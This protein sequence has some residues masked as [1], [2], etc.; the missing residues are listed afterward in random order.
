MWPHEILSFV[1]RRKAPMSLHFQTWL[2]PS[3]PVLSCMWIWKKGRMR[4]W[5]RVCIVCVQQ[6][7]TGLLSPTQKLSTLIKDLLL[8]LRHWCWKSTFQDRPEEKKQNCSPM[9]TPLMVTIG[10]R[11]I[12]VKSTCFN[13]I[14]FLFCWLFRLTF[15]FFALAKLW[16]L[17]F[18]LSQKARK[19]SI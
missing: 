18:F 15:C 10:L 4:V 1:Y 9:L 2:T 7:R 6:V 5:V 19:K 13:N 3:K 17:Q 16:P 11:N 14:L 8:L 12:S